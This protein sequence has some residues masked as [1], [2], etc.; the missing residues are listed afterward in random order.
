[1]GAFVSYDKSTIS[2]LGIKVLNFIENII[3]E[4]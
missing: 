1:M 2:T 4:V 3:Q